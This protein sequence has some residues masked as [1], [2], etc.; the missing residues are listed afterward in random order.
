M[1][2]L[3]NLLV[4]VAKILDIALSI[5]M[6]I[7]VA[8]AVISW[9]NADPYNQIVQFLYRITEPVLSRTRRWI[10][11]GNMGID[12][13]PMIV[14]LVILF[15]QTFLVRSLLEMASYFR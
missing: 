8:R 7:I 3:S 10:P 9:V 1:F 15:L 5:Y 12:F 6:W 11:F 2:V 14:I 13:A 4:A